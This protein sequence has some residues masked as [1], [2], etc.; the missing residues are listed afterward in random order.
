MFHNLTYTWYCWILLIFLI[1]CIRNVASFLLMH[2]FLISIVFEYI[3]T[4]THIYAHSS[5]FHFEL[6]YFFYSLRYTHTNTTHAHRHSRFKSLS[7]A[8]KKNSSK[9][10]GIFLIL[11]IVLYCTGVERAWKLLTLSP[12][13]ALFIFSIWFFLN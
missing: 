5:V 11:F 9:M 7:D 12:Y 8:L 13:L 2:S 4:H 10:K 3:F 1:W 6:L